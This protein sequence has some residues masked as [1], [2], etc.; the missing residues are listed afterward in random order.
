M[1]AAFIGAIFAAGLAGSAGAQSVVLVRA[2]NLPLWG[3]PAPL[4]RELRLGVLDGRD[5]QSFGR[6]VGIAVSRDGQL[7]IADAQASTIRRFDVNGRYLGSVGRNGEGPGEF[8]NLAGLQRTPGGR[9]AAW[10]SRLKRVSFFD[11]AGEYIE[12][13]R[14]PARYEVG[15]SLESFRVGARGELYVLGAT[16]TPPDPTFHLFYLRLRG[17]E[18]PDTV[19]IPAPNPRGPVRGIRSYLLGGMYP[20]SIA[21]YSAL[22]PAGHLVTGRNDQY[23]LHSRTDDGRPLRIERSYDPV[24]VQTAERREAERLG[25]HFR[26]RNPGSLETATAVPRV[27]PPFWNLW[28]DQDHRIWVARHGRGVPRPETAA[29]RE[30]RERFDNP[31]SEWWDPLEF[32]VIDR[33][34]RFL[35]S[36][37]FANIQAKPMF[38][39]GSRVWVLE[40]GEYG[41]QYVVRYVIDSSTP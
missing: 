33:R 11:D 16:V 34:G 13:V 41:E 24:R 35:G 10:D 20:F 7:W 32:D 19:R 36:I 9:V 28:V 29:E 31:P 26:R 15:S 5:E 3:D 22:T 40:Q 1:R 37:R 38:A 8:R 25:D 12:T 4:R 14:V 17:A 27:K 6:I 21:T 18:A 2:D 23:A 30:R 39:E